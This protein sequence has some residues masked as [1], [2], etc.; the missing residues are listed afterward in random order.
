MLRHFRVSH[1]GVPEGDWFVF[2]TSPLPVYEE[3][4]KV[5]ADIINNGMINV[6]PDGT[7][8]HS[9]GCTAVI[10]DLPEYLK[11]IEKRLASQ[12][13]RIAIWEGLPA[14]LNGQPV[15]IALEPEISRINYPDH[16]HINLGGMAEDFYLP[17]SIC[18]TDDPRELG[19]DSCIR[20]REAAILVCIW[21]F[22]HQIWLAS[23]AKGNATWIGPQIDSDA[24]FIGQPFHLNP[25]GTCRCG[26]EKH[27]FQCHMFQDMKDLGIND[28]NFN[29]RAYHSHWM[30]NIGIP[31]QKALNLLRQILK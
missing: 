29:I 7:L 12:T 1:K 16:P 11:K 17:D 21:L 18:Y 22:R 3:L 27:Y 6:A 31:H 19:D 15:A 25:L 24:R 26:S 13:F 10:H 2:E 28:K 14:L 9:N 5:I 30:T 20:I 4:R 8:H 23:R